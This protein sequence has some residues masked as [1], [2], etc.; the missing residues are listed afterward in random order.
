MHVA[1]ELSLLG[2]NLEKTTTEKSCKIVMGNKGGNTQYYASVIIAPP[3]DITIFNFGP[4]RVDVLA[5]IVTTYIL[6]VLGQ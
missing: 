1:A 6:S 2:L 5:K 3:H 4:S